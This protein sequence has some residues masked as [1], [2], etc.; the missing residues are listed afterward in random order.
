MPQ[1]IVITQKIW[2]K[3]KTYIIASYYYFFVPTNHC[4]RYDNEIP[5]YNICTIPFLLFIYCISLRNKNKNKN[6]LRKILNCQIH[7]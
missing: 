7:E 6:S 1:F 4:L 3:L 5:L 2:H